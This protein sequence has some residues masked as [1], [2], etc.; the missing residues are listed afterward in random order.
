MNDIESNPLR[1]ITA[2]AKEKW[3]KNVE[4]QKRKS[5]S[6]KNESKS[7]QKRP[8]KQTNTNVKNAP[9]SKKRKLH[10]SRRKKKW[11]YDLPL[12]QQKLRSLIKLSKMPMGME[13]DAIRIFFTQFGFVTR[14][15]LKRHRYGRSFRE[16]YVEYDHPKVA[17]IVVDALDTTSLYGEMLICTEIAP[18]DVRGSEFFKTYSLEASRL[19]KKHEFTKRRWRNAA[20]IA[21]LEFQFDGWHKK[22]IK[23]EGIINKNR[24]E[25]G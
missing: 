3:K 12:K 10:H 14:F 18:E 22:L 21:N 17:K 11:D 5:K 25:H 19:N 8:I 6:A 20:T 16:G 24:K 23:D 13:E 9:P 7:N 15:C 1:A 4:Q 2:K